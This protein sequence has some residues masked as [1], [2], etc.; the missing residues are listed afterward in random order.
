MQQYPSS[1]IY[2][3]TQN[4][5]RYLSRPPHSI[6]SN[7]NYHGLFSPQIADPDVIDSE[8][9]DRDSAIE[10]SIIANLRL[11]QSGPTT[12]TNTERPFLLQQSLDASPPIHASRW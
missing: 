8:K 4:L 11:W 2:T 3:R 7:Y 10:T 12:T 9:R 6:A 1:D 5:S